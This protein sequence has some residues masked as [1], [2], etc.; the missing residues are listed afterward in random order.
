MSTTTCTCYFSN[1]SLLFNPQ[2]GPFRSISALPKWYQTCI[3]DSRKEYDNIRGKKCGVL[4]VRPDDDGDYP[5]VDVEY[6]W[7]MCNYNDFD[8]ELKDPQAKMYD[9]T[10]KKGDKE[11]NVANPRFP[12]GGL[13]LPSGNCIERE[14]DLDL[15]TAN[16]YN[17]AT[18][19]EGF[20]IDENGNRKPPATG[21][22]EDLT[23]HADF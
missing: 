3:T 8:I 9:W 14:E 10:M 4:N 22:Y 5:V 2:K 15:N 18:Q 7:S 20:V 21:M 12:L 17:L 23:C 1:S 19:L 13:A 16:R 6:T 11:K